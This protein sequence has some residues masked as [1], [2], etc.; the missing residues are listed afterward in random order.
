M[1][2]IGVYGGSFNP[3]HIGHLRT[4]IEVRERVGLAQVWLV[5]AS[6][7][8]HKTP[9]EI[10]PAEQRLAMI[11][12]AIASVP[13]LRA[14]PV[15]L[16][17]SGPSY[18]VDTL[19]ILRERHPT[20]DFAM[21]LGWDAFRDLHTW[22]EYE[23]L[24]AT[25]DLIVTTRPPDPVEPGENEALFS[26]LPIAVTRRFCYQAS[27]GCYTHDSGHRL[28]FLPVT[29]LDVS[30]STLRADVARG[31]SIRFL[32]PEEVRAYILEHGLY[33]ASA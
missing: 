15:E 6:T 25:C 10:A 26:K 14:E 33:L 24:V 12:R 32:V 4:A 31:A 29:Q 13:E 22:H 5:P 3:V 23:R 9:A 8:P 18:S 7:P 21:I 17:R 2:R 11:E 20:L 16:E 19:D 30:A 28:E 27:I 1:P